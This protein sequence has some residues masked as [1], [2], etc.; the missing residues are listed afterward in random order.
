MSR[1]D[2]PCSPLA[3]LPLVLLLLLGATLALTA[4]GSDDGDETTTV[5]EQAGATSGPTDPT[6]PSGVASSEVSRA[7]AVA[8]VERFYRLLNGSRYSEAW[9]FVPPEVRTDSGGY[10][11]WKA[12]YR[13]NIRSVPSNLTV[14]SI[15][16]TRAVVTLDLDAVDID[17]CT[18]ENVEQLFSGTWTLRAVDGRWEPI[19]ASF[20]KVSGGTPTL[21]ASECAPTKPSPTP[22]E[23]CTPG[24]SPCLVPASDYDC[25]GPGDGPEYVSGPV[26][27]TGDDPF[28]LDRDANGIGCE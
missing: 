2:Q 18:G 3:A 5:I 9:A 27:V 12:G 16:A 26:Q 15:T 6:G 14:D 13:A 8:V 10:A 25:E 19:A 11:N 22:G 20:D 21:S 24:Y 7:E 1:R 23:N 28:D 17:A 4:C